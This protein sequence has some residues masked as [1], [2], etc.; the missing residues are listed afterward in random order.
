MLRRSVSIGVPV[1]VSSPG[2]MDAVI[3]VS[4][5]VLF[6]DVCLSTIVVMLDQC[7]TPRG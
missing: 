1:R 3:C 4:A 5:D 6:A 7:A 2:H